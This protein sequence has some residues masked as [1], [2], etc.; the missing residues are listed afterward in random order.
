MRLENARIYRP[1]QKP[2]MIMIDLTSLG[3]SVTQN[4]EKGLFAARRRKL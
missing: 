1:V 2:E 4:Q 3:N